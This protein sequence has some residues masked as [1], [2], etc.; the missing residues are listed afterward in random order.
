MAEWLKAAVLNS[1]INLPDF[2]QA[3]LN[4]A[5]LPDLDFPGSFI[6]LPDFFLGKRYKTRP[7]VG[8]KGRAASSMFIFLFM[9]QVYFL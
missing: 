1:A 2:F 7:V 8:E 5:L 3:S 4:Q 9:R 6:K